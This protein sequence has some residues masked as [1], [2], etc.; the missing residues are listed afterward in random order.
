[1][2]PPVKYPIYPTAE[3]FLQPQQPRIIDQYIVGSIRLELSNDD[4]YDL[5]TIQPLKSTYC[6]IIKH[7]HSYAQTAHLINIKI[8]L[9]T[10]STFCLL[11]LD[12]IKIS[13]H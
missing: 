8:F 6:I 3:K 9:L 4:D 10:I 2:I 13:I 12:I 5:K 11:F 1:M 7:A